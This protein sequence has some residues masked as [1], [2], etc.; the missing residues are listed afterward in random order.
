MKN[1]PLRSEAA[2]AKLEDR[3]RSRDALPWLSHNYNAVIIGD[4]V[5]P[6]MQAAIDKLNACVDFEDNAI[7]T[8]T[9][10]PVDLT[11]NRKRK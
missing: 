8:R 1:V 6:L 7:D 3:G 9:L 5:K 2:S 11:N 4:L 10:I